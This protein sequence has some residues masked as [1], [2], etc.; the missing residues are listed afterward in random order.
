MKKA[1][2]VV[3]VQ[4]DFCP[5]G[6]LAV[7][8]GDEVVPII[9]KLLP[10]FD[11]IIFTKDWHFKEM[12]AF[13]SHQAQF[14]KQAFDKY[15]N[16][17]GQEDIVWPDHC[18]EDTEGAEFHPDLDLGKCKKDFYIFKKGNMPHFHPYS[19]FPDTELANFLN[20]REVERVYIVG[21]ALDY[22]VADTA[23][24][25]AMEGFD[26][27]VIEDATRPINDDINDTLKKFKEAN[28]K[29]IESWEI[30]MYELM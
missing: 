21:L 5:G 4:N 20:E 18:V 12:Y 22:C 7:P 26:T 10:K 24:D 23:I 25:A 14:G 9:N 30:E 11:L 8:H 13:A 17:Q 29:L 6:S 28:I 1:L 16:E 27:V 15:V 3:D 2:I 19:A